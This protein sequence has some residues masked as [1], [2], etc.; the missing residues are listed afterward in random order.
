MRKVN[1]S[2]DLD[3]DTLKKIAEAT[4]GKYFRARDTQ[5][6]EQIY[7]L[8]DELEPV[9]KETQNFRPTSA[10]FIWP[11]G[12]ALALAAILVLKRLAR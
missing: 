3:E 1:P 8:L 10:L 12:L 9:T 4:G 11:L 2:T 7:Q 5:D 6:L